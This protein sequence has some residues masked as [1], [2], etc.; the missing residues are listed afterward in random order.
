MAFDQSKDKVLWEGEVGD[1][2]ISVHSYNDGEPKLQIGPRMTEKDGEAPGYRK[3]GRI[4][5]E[6]VSYIM[7]HWK[8]DILTAMEGSPK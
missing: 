3:A 5:L 4:S 1:L 6:E 8:K 2:Q 7:T